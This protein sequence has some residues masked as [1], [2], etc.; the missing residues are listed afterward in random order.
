[1]I[2]APALRNI[3]LLSFAV[4]H[5]LWIASIG[6]DDPSPVVIEDA[7]QHVRTTAEREWAWFPENAPSQRFEREFE[8]SSHDEP[9]TLTLRQQNVKQ[10]WDV[11]KASS[12]ARRA[13][14][15]SVVAKLEGV[16]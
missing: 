7:L 3:I 9:W 10:S 1:M 12:E 4:L 11:A 2:W 14:R 15:M 8:S 6:A 16:E 5:W 13:D